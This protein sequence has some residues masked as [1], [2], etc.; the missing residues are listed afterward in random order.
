MLRIRGILSLLLI[1]ACSLTIWAKPSSL[2]SATTSQYLSLFLGS[3][4][5]DDKHSIKYVQLEIET[6]LKKVDNNKQILKG[7]SKGIKALNKLLGKEYF[8][9]YNQLA[10]FDMIFKT[11]TYNEATASALLLFILEHLQWEYYL[12]HEVNI[13]S[14]IVLDKEDKINVLPENLRATQADKQQFIN[15]YLVLLKELQEISHIPSEAT[16]KTTLFQKNYISTTKKLS[17]QELAGELYF[18][19]AL[20][21]YIYKDYSKALDYLHKTD[22]LYR[23]PRNQII[24]KACLFQQIPTGEKYTEDELNRLILLHKTHPL[25]ATK[26]QLFKAYYYEVNVAFGAKKK[27]ITKATK[28]KHKYLKLIEKDPLF[29]QSV[30]RIYLSKA[31]Q[32]YSSIND[33]KKSLAY[34]DSLYYHWPSNKD[35]QSLITTLLVNK[36]SASQPYNQGITQVEVLKTKY[37]FLYNNKLIG[38]LH[39]NFLSQRIRYYFEHDMPQ[40]GIDGLEEFERY[41]TIYGPTQKIGI[42]LITTY[43]SASYYYFLKEDYENAKYFINKGLLLQPDNKF[44]QH[45][46]ELLSNY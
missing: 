25:P 6:L 38:D 30:E 41:L 21:K 3:S 37:P 46:S 7:G 33:N 15:D 14:P 32:Y 1:I 23:L 31:A 45:R 5:Q 43:A 28:V 44:F 13:L 36:V 20:K 8:Q 2:S 4:S 11:K 24:R 26:A 40:S 35:V 29:E 39:L 27:A 10:S 18:Q 9:N 42:W 17:V 19:Q 12:L 34:I 16:Q 22:Q